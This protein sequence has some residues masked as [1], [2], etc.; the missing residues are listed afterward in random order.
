MTQESSEEP[1]SGCCASTW[2]KGLCRPLCCLGLGIAAVVALL[3]VL[4]C[5]AGAGCSCD[6]E[7]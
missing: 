6:S 7:A 3:L 5:K 4:R 2:C 1:E